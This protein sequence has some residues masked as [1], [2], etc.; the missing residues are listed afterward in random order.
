MILL[1][2]PAF[3]DEK[4]REEI[5]NKEIC[6]NEK[7]PLTGV[8]LLYHLSCYPIPQG[9]VRNSIKDG[10]ELE[11]YDLVNAKISAFFFGSQ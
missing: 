11:R 3:H 10:A 1:S 9:Q 2:K 6:F 8:A 5:K 4:N 7:F